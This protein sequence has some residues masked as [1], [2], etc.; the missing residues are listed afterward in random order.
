MVDDEPITMEVVQTFLEEFGYSR[1]VLIDDSSKAIAALEQHSP[2]V[3]LLDLI[4][5]GKSGLE[6]LTEIRNHPRLK[7]L[8]VIV[9]TASSEAQDKLN[10][11]EIGA[12]DF[13]SKPV[14]QSE[15]GLRLR[16]TLAAK[17]YIDQL[18]FY[19]PLTKLPNKDLFQTQFDWALEKAKSFNQNL[20][21]FN[22]SLDHF[23]RINATIGAKAAD[24]LLIEIATRLKNLA[25]NIDLLS[26]SGENSTTSLG[27]YRIEGTT[28]T[29][30]LDQPKTAESA[31]MVAERILKIIREP[32]RIFDIEIA[33]TA[34]IGL[35]TFPLEGSNSGTLR[36]LAASA[37]DFSK[38]KGGDCF[39]YSSKEI[40]TIYEKRFQLE[41]RLRKALDNDELV[42]YYQPKVKVSN[43]ELLGVEALI[44][45][46]SKELGL[47]PPNDFIPLAEETKLILPIGEW[48]LLEACKHQVKWCKMGIAPVVVSV[49]LSVMQLEDPTLLAMVKRALEMTGA[50]P[51]YIKLE[52]TESLLLNDIEKKIKLLHSLKALGVGL[53]IDDFGTGY[54]SLSYLARLPVDELKIDRSFIMDVETSEESRA[55]VSSV[56]FL[57]HSLKLLTVA[58][59]I[60]TLPQLD[61]ISEQGCDQYQGYHFS[62]PVPVDDIVKLM[63][64]K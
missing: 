29:L 62:R 37:K 51:K 27:P 48:V 39:H 6:V 19:D 50:D 55:I 57:A 43:G 23:S 11:L 60:E 12:T 46:Q 7:R 4:M 41:S 31:A 28:F 24:A 44:R 30:L 8:P 54:S 47:I 36:R 21:L 10:A 58:E 33:V 13:L 56:V 52:L 18:A 38:N 34:S 25:R 59:G 64:K 17:A 2:D 40:N 22:I 3:L 14:D 49:N 16:N 9:L 26:A 1:F 15:L 32:A 45:W 20:V 53:S 42:L 35:T 63:R 61:F 5:P